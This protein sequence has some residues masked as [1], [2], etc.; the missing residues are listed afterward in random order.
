MIKGICIMILW[1][2]AGVISLRDAF[3]AQGWRR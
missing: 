3:F 1:V 2:A